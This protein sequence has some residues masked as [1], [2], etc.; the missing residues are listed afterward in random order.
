MAIS[1]KEIETRFRDISPFNLGVVQVMRDWNTGLHKVYYTRD[2]HDVVKGNVPT[3]FCACL[4]AEVLMSMPAAKAP[5]YWD[6][7]VHKQGLE[8]EVFVK[9]QC[10]I[11]QFLEA[12]ISGLGSTVSRRLMTQIYRELGIP[13]D[14]GVVTLTPE[15]VLARNDI[16]RQV[17]QHH[18][19]YSNID[20]P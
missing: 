4:K 5:E 2:V 10:A 7:I 20:A 11:W 3:W 15:Q 6:L 9:G 14:A 19:L 1:D 17:L 16:A 12:W 18:L 8:A 13:K